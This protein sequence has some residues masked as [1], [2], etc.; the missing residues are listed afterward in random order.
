MMKFLA[1][2]YHDVKLSF[3]EEKVWGMGC[4]CHVIIIIHFLNPKFCSHMFCTLFNL[5]I[6]VEKSEVVSF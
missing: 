2:H 4:V 1:L 3:M 6:E 5:Q